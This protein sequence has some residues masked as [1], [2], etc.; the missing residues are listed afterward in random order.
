MADQTTR[1]LTIEMRKAALDLQRE[2]A[3][4]SFLRA[5]W[6]L[7]QL[8]HELRF[9]PDQPRVPAG[10]SD[11]G[12]WTASDDG[13]EVT[14]V[15]GRPRPPA[16]VTLNGRPVEMTPTQ[17]GRLASARAGAQTAADRVRELDPTWE[18]RERMGEPGS[19]EGAIRQAEA[20]GREANQRLAELSRG[21]IGDN[22]G[23]ALA[24]PS[25]SRGGITAQ[26][27]EPADVIA[28]YRQITGMRD[29]VGGVAG[30]S[31]DRTVAY[32]EIDGRP[33]IGVS[34]R[35]PGYTD[36]DDAAARDMRDQLIRAF[37]N[38]MATANLG[39]MPN[40]ALFHAEANAL[41]RA[42]EPHNGN[43]AGRA[44]DI[45]VDRELCPNCN[46]VLPLI[47][48]RLGNPTVRFIDPLG[49]VSIMKH[50][51]WQRGW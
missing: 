31:S 28:A 10:N 45:W 48:M 35:S 11:G 14:P 13:A 6:R 49:D 42:A 41:L 40:N 26:R 43:L 4:L 50:G 29:T 30:L 22:Q 44:L 19:V 32:T 37:P 36:A 23:P 25:P 20:E 2:I 47:G 18:P 3:A 7:C 21:R 46:T 39:H 15:S 38:E 33:V 9:H 8:L 51:R 1:I 27:V 16:T 17:S 34:S 12:Q 24:E 5:G